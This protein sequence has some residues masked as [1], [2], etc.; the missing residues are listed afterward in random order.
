MAKFGQVTTVPCDSKK[1]FCK[2]AIWTL[3]MHVLRYFCFT[4]EQRF[5]T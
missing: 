5:Q 4:T 1:H 2:S 3:Q